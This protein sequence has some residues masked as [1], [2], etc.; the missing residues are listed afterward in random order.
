MVGSGDP[1]AVVD[2]TRLAPTFFG[3]PSQ[4][5]LSGE[6]LAWNGLNITGSQPCK[7]STEH[8]FVIHLQLKSGYIDIIPVTQGQNDY[9]FVLARPPVEALVT[10]GEVKTV[11]SL[12][13]DD[14]KKDDLFLITTKQRSGVFENELTLV[15]LDDR[16]YQNDSDI[17]QSCLNT[18]P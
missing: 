13:T 17:K 2:D 18:S 7:L 4:A 15:N 5:I 14:R 10:E 8:S 9:E 1:V 3:D 6:V 11:Y 16:Y 12:S